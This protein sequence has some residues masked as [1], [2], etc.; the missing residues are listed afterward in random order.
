MQNQTQMIRRLRVTTLISVLIVLS[1]VVTG[2]G[3]YSIK[4]TAPDAPGTTFRLAYHAGNQQYV[5]DSVVTD[6]SGTG[7]FSG[8]ERLPSGVYMIVT[9]EN[10]FFEFLV[11]KDPS[12]GMSF[13]LSDPASSLSF[14]GSEEN[15]RFLEYQRGWRALQEE[16]TRI[17]GRLNS[18]KHDDPQA[19][20]IR[21]ELAEHE[22][23][24]KA[25]LN[26]SAAANSGNLLGAIARSVIPVEA[27]APQI[28]PG[29]ANPDSVSRLYSYLYY[30]EHFFDNTDLTQ[31][32]L[33]RSPV[34]W[35]KLDQFF[36]Q[37]VV[38]MPDSINAEADRILE[39]S[40][41]NE[42]VFQYVAI[43]LMNRYAASEIMGH[44]AVVVHLAD[45]IYLAGK[46]PWASEEY[47]A[48]LK[49]RVERLRPNLIGRKAPDLVMES[50]TG[51]WVALHDIKA[52]FT[53]L[54]FWEPDCGHCK[55]ATPKLKEYYD[56]N[57]M[58]GIEVFA[59][60][61]RH[62]REE[63]EK[64]IRENGL[65]WI[66]GWDPGRVSRFDLLYNV[67]ATPLVYILDREKTI[68][69]KRLSVDDIPSFI[70]SYRKYMGN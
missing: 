66:N 21:K 11:D 50:Y 68:I 39:K 41:A 32:G 55:V 46:A 35:G 24:M 47:I 58:S 53:I 37:V 49:K 10:S 1:S 8:D 14:T 64:Y 4:I 45:R 9:P 19:A 22:K 40:A 23:K 59:V 28:P 57:R 30:K 33:I 67:E 26:E 44:D 52:E 29:T 13:R 31:P 61:T 5:R 70:E 48:E 54:Y 43:W 3:G 34:L 16:A 18:M 20:A 15:S 65:T 60:N 42:E 17:S 63:W 2:Q 12:F 6:R 62:E 69:A 38:Q 7:L 51:Q 27:P 36:R 25:F 56:K